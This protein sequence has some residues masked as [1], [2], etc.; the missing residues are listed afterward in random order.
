MERLLPASFTE[1]QG[2]LL[3]LAALIVALLSLSQE[4]RSAMART[5]AVLL[6]ASMLDATVSEMGFLDNLACLIR[7]IRRGE[8]PDQPRPRPNTRMQHLD[9]TV[10]E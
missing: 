9:E 6:I 3:L 10:S 2:G 5:S 8:R 4:H 7:G 1:L